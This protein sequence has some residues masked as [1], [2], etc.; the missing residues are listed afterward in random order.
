VLKLRLH[1]CR[2]KQKHASERRLK[3]SAKPKRKPG[4]VL[5]KQRDARRK[6]TCAGESTKKYAVGPKKKYGDRPKLKHR[7][8]RLK[9]LVYGWKWK[10]SF[11]LRRN[12][13]LMRK[14]SAKR[15]SEGPKKPFGLGWLKRRV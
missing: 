6:K 15:K 12:A 5:L 8:A 9:K 3:R 4:S 2:L 1:A 7:L 13:R 14:Q 10:R 11:V